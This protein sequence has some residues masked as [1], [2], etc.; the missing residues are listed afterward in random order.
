MDGK[1]KNCREKNEIRTVNPV[2]EVFTKNYETVNNYSN[3]P[4]TASLIFIK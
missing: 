2:S 1:E 3:L 4:M